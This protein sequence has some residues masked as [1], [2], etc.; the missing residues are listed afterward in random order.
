MNAPYQKEKLEGGT[1]RDVL[2]DVDR[3]S[4]LKDE[5]VLP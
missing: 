3:F 1:N 4:A 2:S 5:T